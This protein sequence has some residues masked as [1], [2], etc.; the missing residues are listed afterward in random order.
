MIERSGKVMEP[1]SERQA[2]I[3]A[4]ADKQCLVTDTKNEFYDCCGDGSSISAIKTCEVFGCIN[5]VVISLFL[6]AYIGGYIH[7]S[8][9]LEA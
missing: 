2:T 5:V 9:W 8:R 7:Q 4:E 6:I 3:L 1:D